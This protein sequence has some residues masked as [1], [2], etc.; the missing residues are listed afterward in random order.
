MVATPR[1]HASPTLFSSMSWVPL[2]F[3]LTLLA[4]CSTGSQVP[5]EP[6]AASVAPPHDGS[7]ATPPA[8]KFETA[9]KPLLK[10]SCVSCH[11]P[12]DLEGDLDLEKFLMAT[13]TDALKQRK[14]WETVADK[15][16]AMEMPP[17]GERQPSPEE[18]AV[19]I[20]SIDQ[21][22]AA[23]D[24]NSPLNPGRVVA[25][26]LNRIEYNNTIRD[27][28]GVNLRITEDFPPDPSG[29]GFDNIGDVLSLSPIL[30]EKYLKA[31][32]D[33][34]QL[35]I[36]LT[37]VTAVAA[38][39]NTE[40]MGQQFRELV[41]IKHD[42]PVDGVYTIRV[43]WEQG[44][45]VG[46]RHLGSVF[47]DGREIVNQTV[48]FESYEGQ[49]RSIYAR[50][51]RIPRGTHVFEARVEALPPEPKPSAEKSKKGPPKI[52]PPYPTVVEIVGPAE[53]VAKED[54]DSYRQIFFQGPP[55][56]DAGPGSAR[57]IFARLLPRAY[58]RPVSD[59]EI[60]QFTRLTD[61]VRA[62][63][64]SFEE[65]IQV[66]L[67]AMLVSPHFLFRIERDPRETRERDLYR[68]SDLEL[69]SR[70]SYF[71]W[72]SM[73]DDTLLA[74]AAGERLHETEVLHTQVRRMLADPKARSLARNFASQWLQTRNLDVNAPDRGT[75]PDFDP[76]L[77]DAIQQETELFFHAVVTEDRDVL[78]FL[79]GKFTFL[80]ERLAR[81]YGISG[82]EGR[83]FRRIELDGNER[84]G[85]LTHA[86]V[87]T[88]SSYP[89]RTSPVIRG[90]WLLENILNSPPPPPPPN[91]PA[92]DEALVGKTVSFR[93]QLEQHR[94]NAACASCHARMDPL[95]FG[96]E[97]YDA[98]GR[99]RNRDGGFEIDASGRLPGNRTFV[100]P[101]ELKAILRADS[102]RF[103]RAFSA[104]LMIFALG[105][106]LESYDRRAV[107]KVARHAEQNE[108]RFSEVVTA[109]VESAPFQMR[110]RGHAPTLTASADAPAP[111]R[112]PPR[113]P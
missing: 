13:A 80:N 90:K 60:A 110:T 68:I 100:G 86:S 74:L 92:L 26:R 12:A 64:G 5:S 56:A 111:D 50:H 24:L 19:A 108:R 10:A 17:E 62:R 81:H 44:N 83:E 25:R 21:Y 96:L 22:Y 35:A 82:V 54:T 23:V 38:R 107:E 30:T 6:L 72:S 95:G 29:Y 75:F 55:A 49:D 71:L 11:N 99:W 61:L 70:L 34:A 18:A 106:G 85:I 20:E 48:V 109:I 65:G 112:H 69:A 91:V 63:G 47:L 45:P 104:K 28:L 32:E 8:T 101:K 52:L 88:V 73:P 43:G 15:M 51:V 46:T 33:V 78:D 27:L 41:R 59:S 36:P 7:A 4:G 3:S 2:T 84:S 14:I 76:E 9:L 67:T 94:S 77:R 113:A 40:T 58:R 103:I 37:K 39:Y 87:L 89:T 16:R 98:I 1:P 97:N 105:R 93:A 79:D 57:E 102:P 42:I 53:Q 66:G 31:A